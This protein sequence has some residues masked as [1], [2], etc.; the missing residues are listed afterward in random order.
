M[1]I[2]TARQ[3][4]ECSPSTP[5]SR[6]EAISWKFSEAEHTISLKRVDFV[7]NCERW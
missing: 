5:A 2:I 1:S 7:E 3:S 6:S 4:A